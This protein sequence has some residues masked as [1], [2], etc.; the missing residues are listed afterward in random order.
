MSNESVAKVQLLVS[1]VARAFYADKYILALDY[2][3]EK[4]RLASIFTP[5]IL[6]SPLFIPPT[7]TTVSLLLIHF[8]FPV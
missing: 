6:I 5:S 8:F 3:N 2:L 7:P 1:V 4:E